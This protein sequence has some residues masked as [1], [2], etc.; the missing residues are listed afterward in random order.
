MINNFRWQP[1]GGEHPIPK[2]L[3]QSNPNVS[4]PYTW[5]YCGTKVRCPVVDHTVN[6]HEASILPACLPPSLPGPCRTSHFLMVPLLLFQRQGWAACLLL[7]PLCCLSC[8][9]VLPSIPS[10]LPKSEVKPHLLCMTVSWSS[11]LSPEL[12]EATSQKETSDDTVPLF[13]TT[14][15]APHLL[16]TEA[17]ALLCGVGCLLTLAPL[18]CPFSFSWPRWLSSQQTHVQELQCS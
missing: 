11:L 8:H 18:L 5:L 6:K 15:S 10:L 14:L 13:P 17:M 1:V 9:Q 12:L 3:W 16:Q 7:F 4:I 2:G